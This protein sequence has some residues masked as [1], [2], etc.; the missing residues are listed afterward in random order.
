M[1]N[2]TVVLTTL[3]NILLLTGLSNLF[4]HREVCSSIFIIMYARNV[5]GVLTG[6]ENRYSY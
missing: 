2:I 3:K 4:A 5:P 1:C 6:Q